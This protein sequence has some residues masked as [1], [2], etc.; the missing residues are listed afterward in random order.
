MSE[1]HPCALELLASLLNLLFTRV[2]QDLNEAAASKDGPRL[3]NSPANPGPVKEPEV[4]DLSPSCWCTILRLALAKA[5]G[6]GTTISWAE[7]RLVLQR[8]A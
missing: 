4:R 5:N 6:L 7:R 8:I 1:P 2:S 3:R